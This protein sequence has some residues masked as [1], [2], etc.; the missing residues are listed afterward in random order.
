LFGHIRLRGG[1]VDGQNSQAA[2]GIERIDRACGQKAFTI[3]QFMHT[4][5]K[6][7]RRGVNHARR[8]FFATDLEQ[9]IRHVN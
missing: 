4:L 9:K 5:A 1:N 2:R 3:Q 8:N 6:F 7:Q